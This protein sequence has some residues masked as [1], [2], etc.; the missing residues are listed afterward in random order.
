MKKILKKPITSKNNRR[1]GINEAIIKKLR[2]AS[3][4]DNNYIYEMLQS[5]ENGLTRIMHLKKLIFCIFN[6]NNSLQGRKN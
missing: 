5:D 1:N 3:L 2:L 4:G 6:K